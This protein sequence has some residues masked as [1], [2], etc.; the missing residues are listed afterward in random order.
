MTYINDDLV[1][2]SK[3][4][5]NNAKFPRHYWQSEKNICDCGCSKR[6]YINN[7]YPICFNKL[8]EQLNREGYSVNKNFCRGGSDEVK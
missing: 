7:N 2:K 6:L 8:V 1:H 4:G 3:I 5:I